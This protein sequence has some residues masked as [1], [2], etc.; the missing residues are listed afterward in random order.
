[1]ANK[2]KDTIEVASGGKVVKRDDDKKVVTVILGS[3][4]PSIRK[5]YHCHNCGRIV[6]NYYSEVRIIIAG[7]MQEVSRPVDLY[8]SRCKLVHRIV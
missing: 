4:D 2:V 8:C 7:E 1:L 6:F 5:D 3:F